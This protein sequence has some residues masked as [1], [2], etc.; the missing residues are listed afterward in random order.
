VERKA[1]H[2]LPPG[3]VGALQGEALTFRN[4]GGGEGGGGGGGRGG[5][6]G[7]RPRCADARAVFVNVRDPGDPLRELL[8]PLTVLS[9]FARGL[10][11]W[12]LTLWLVRRGKFAVCLHWEV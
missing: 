10:L 1:K 3:L 4:G 8:N 6:G 7:F 2:I 9:V 5:G 11:G 12:L